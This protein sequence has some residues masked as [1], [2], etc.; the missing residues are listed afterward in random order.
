MATWALTYGAA[1]AERGI[2]PRP[3]L[4]SA[5]DEL[6]SVRLAGN[7]PERFAAR[8]GDTEAAALAAALGQCDQATEVDLSY[9]E[10]SDEG[11]RALADMLRRTTALKH[12]NLAYNDIGHRGWRTLA[13]AL[14]ANTTL[15]TLSVAG[16][17]IGGERHS[18][19][20]DMREVGGIACG[21]MLKMNRTL[22]TV[23]FSACELGVC[24]IVGVA[25]AMITQ[26]SVTSLNLS[27]PL[28]PGAQEGLS[29]AQHLS[30]MLR[31]N[32]TLETLNLS[33]FK[34]TDEQFSIM[35]PSLVFNDGLRHLLLSSNQLSQDGGAEIGK[36]LARRHDICSIDLSSNKI[37]N[38]GARDIAHT[39]KQNQGVESLDLSY[40]AIG[41]EGLVAVAEGLGSNSS[42][43]TLKLWG[44]DWT[45]RASQTFYAHRQ[46]L[47]QMAFI[48]FEFCVVDGIPQVLLA[49]G[50]GVRSRTA[51]FP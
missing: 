10:I 30:E 7:A 6:Q 33:R 51:N 14:M 21:T 22:R 41:E 11:A 5:G 42:V 3:E 39:L 24:S 35:L 48:D 4:K 17:A 12:L 40:C 44:N 9:N 27:N 19:H 16:N 28:L 20:S 1:C 13:D 29:V 15:E 43:S 38:R 45:Q 26:G 36:L 47:E 49:P 31:K 50:G 37:D 18:A 34:L 25:Q 8:V 23:D 32:N 46:R 2:L